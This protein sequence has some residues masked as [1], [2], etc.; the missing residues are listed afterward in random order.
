MNFLAYRQEKSSLCWHDIF[1]QKE[2]SPD[3][4]S[5]LSVD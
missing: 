5:E 1:A 4:M 2:E 3:A